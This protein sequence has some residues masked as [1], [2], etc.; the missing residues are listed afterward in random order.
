MTHFRQP[1]AALKIIEKMRRGEAPDVL[2][3][4]TLGGLGDVLMTLPTVRAI[5]QQYRG[6]V[7]YATD[8]DYLQG[9]LVKLLQDNP[10]IDNIINWRQMIP[11]N[12]DAHID[13]TCPCVIHEKPQAP[14]VNRIDLF[15]RHAGINLTS[16]HL[17]YHVT[18]KEIEWAQD[19]IEKFKITD[20]H[21]IILLQP[22]SSTVNRDCP[23][24][25]LQKALGQLLRV[26]RDVRVIVI[27]HDTDAYGLNWSYAE[28]STM[29]NYDIRH[30]AAVMYHCDLVIC[31][32][33][34]V[35]HIAGALEKKTI[36]LFGPTDPR[37]RV[38]HYPEAIAIWPGQR[39]ACVPQWFHPCRCSVGC[40]K[41]ITPEMIVDTAIPMLDNNTVPNREYL[42]RFR[43]NTGDGLFEEL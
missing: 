13:L 8:F 24:E 41:L 2:V 35:L 32:D 16:T 31:P 25:T 21:K 15:A 43:H 7:D 4:R 26:R 23:P 19:Y 38:N 9:G 17:D 39:L 14:P 22:H 11:E 33:S 20:R 29:K 18:D 36:A 10:Y 5:K 1:S 28:I 6:R 34:S 37:A 12:Y 3:S 40:W 27:T 42:V 30:I